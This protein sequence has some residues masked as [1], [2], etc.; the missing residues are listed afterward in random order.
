MR[1]SDLRPVERALGLVEDDYMFGRRQI[2]AALIAAYVLADRPHECTPGPA[3]L[4]KHVLQHV[5]ERAIAGQKHC[6]RAPIAPLQEIQPR[7]V[8]DTHAYQCLPGPGYA[9]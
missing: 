1:I 7:I 4:T 3:S 6:W 8:H 2:R 5:D 9:G